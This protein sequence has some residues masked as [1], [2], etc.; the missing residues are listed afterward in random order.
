MNN[1]K[2]ISSGSFLMGANNWGEYEKPVHEVSLDS[3]WMDVAPVSNQEFL[4]FTQNTGYIT[5]AEHKGFAFGCKNGK[6]QNIEGLSWKSY[7]TEDRL[8]HPVVLV[9][10]YDAN[11]YAEWVGKRLPT[12]AEW[13]KAAR[14]TLEQKM[15]PWGDEEPHELIANFNKTVQNIPPT[16]PIKSYPPNEYGLY[17]MAGNVWNWCSD[18]FSEDYYTKEKCNNPQGAKT[19]ITKV[20]KGASF[21]VIQ[22][23]RLRCAN[24]GA[25]L[26]ENYAIN[27]GFRC[28]KDL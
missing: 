11:S 9:S 13:E 17:D 26:P 5:T 20:R 28:V 7:V 4:V 23:F 21:N 27:I 16:T 19:G 10:W 3:Y 8:N 6:M 2:L 22:S 1:M 24:R 14:G 12:E 18:W 25:F 15:Y